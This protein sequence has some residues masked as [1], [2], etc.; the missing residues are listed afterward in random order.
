MYTAQLD[1]NVLPFVI[2]Y[3]R[4][5]GVMPEWKTEMQ[6]IKIGTGRKLSAGSGGKDGKDIAILSFGHVGNFAASA[7][8]M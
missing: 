7:I 1:S 6:E 2:R 4:G 3:T 8:R 5:E